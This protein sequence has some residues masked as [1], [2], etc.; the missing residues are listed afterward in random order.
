MTLKI[1]ETV[2]MEL[3]FKL[4]GDED[5]VI[6]T[7]LVNPATRELFRLLDAAPRMLHAV[8]ELLGTPYDE[9]HEMGRRCAELQ[10][11]VDDIK[12]GV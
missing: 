5:F 9:Y 8:E 2:S 6:T 7:R 11:I 1:T 4:G 12:G 3:R 10:A